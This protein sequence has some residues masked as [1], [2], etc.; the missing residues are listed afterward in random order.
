MLEIGPGLGR[1][2]A[3]FKR[4]LG[5]QDVPFHLYEGDGNDTKYTVL[6]PR[7]D[8]S[9]CGSLA[10]L[11]QSLAYNGVEHARIFD[12]LKL[13][14]RLSALPGPYDW[15]YGFYSVGFH[16]NLEHF[17]DEI[18]GLM[19][20]GTLCSFIVPEHFE[21][22]PRLQELPHRIVDCKCVWPKGRVLRILLLGRLESAAPQLGQ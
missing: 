1:S 11:E 21:P 20:E 17:L 12:A 13:E 7:F 9:F 15:I 2:V 3:F 5:W 10:L 18:L 22:F 19:H 16:W 4:R 8:D 6:G 14:G